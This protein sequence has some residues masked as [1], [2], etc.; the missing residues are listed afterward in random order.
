LVGAIRA[1]RADLWP[2]LPALFRLG[3]QNHSHSP[4]GPGRSPSPSPLHRLHRCPLPPY[5]SSLMREEGSH[6]SQKNS[7]RR[8]RRTPDDDI[9][10]ET[11]PRAKG[12]G[13]QRGLAAPQP[14]SVRLCLIMGRPPRSLSCAACHMH[15]PHVLHVPSSP[16]PCRSF[17]LAPF[18]ARRRVRLGRLDPGTQLPAD[19]DRLVPSH[20]SSGRA[21][22]YLVQTR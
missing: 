2:V 15:G 5:S 10:N 1:R 6:S 22:S 11:R 13:G 4:S 19:S 21:P 8:G 7:L 14:P 20:S 16:I 9:W 17:V 18:G 3:R 12:P